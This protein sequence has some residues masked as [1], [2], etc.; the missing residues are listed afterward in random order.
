MLK[1]FSN[2]GVILQTLIENDN[3]LIYWELDSKY[4]KEERKLFIFDL[5]S[6][7]TKELKLSDE[8][9]EEFYYSHEIRNVN[10]KLIEKFSESM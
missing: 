3:K 6:K 5:K 4:S 8:V 2:I 7:K 1:E 10:K 9:F